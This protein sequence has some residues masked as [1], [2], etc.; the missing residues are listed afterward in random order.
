MEQMYYLDCLLSVI[1]KNMKVRII[2][3][4]TRVLKRGM[5]VEIRS[6]SAPKGC[7][8]MVYMKAILMSYMYIEFDNT[9]YFFGDYVRITL[10]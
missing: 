7:D 4:N 9:V 10:F 8:E 2:L 5:C 3:K 6:I 1:L